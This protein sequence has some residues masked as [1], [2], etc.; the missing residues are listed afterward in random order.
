MNVGQHYKTVLVV[1]PEAIEF[2]KLASPLESARQLAAAM[3]SK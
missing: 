2:G 3:L 1:S